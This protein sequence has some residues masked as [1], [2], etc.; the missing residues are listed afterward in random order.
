MDFWDTE[1]IAELIQKLLT[2]KKLYKACV[3]QGYKDLKKLTWAESA[4][5]IQLLYTKL[6]K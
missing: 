1:K 5:K 2:D 4:R 6:L 3:E